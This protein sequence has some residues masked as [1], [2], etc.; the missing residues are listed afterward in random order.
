MDSKKQL[1][2]ALAA[3][4][5]YIRAEEDERTS[6]SGKDNRSPVWSRFGR[7]VQAQQSHLMQT[8]VRR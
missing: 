6:D 2:A 3:V 1:A 5:A 4:S 8:L 7:E